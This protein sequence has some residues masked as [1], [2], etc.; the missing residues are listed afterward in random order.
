[1]A[2]KGWFKRKAITWMYQLNPECASAEARD[3]MNNVDNE[4]YY[5]DILTETAIEA[6]QMK[7]MGEYHVILIVNPSSEYLEGAEVYLITRD[8]VMPGGGIDLITEYN[9]QEILEAETF[10]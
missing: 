9:L 6:L 1:M 2:T 3:L 7:L 5:E 10:G 8:E 4:S